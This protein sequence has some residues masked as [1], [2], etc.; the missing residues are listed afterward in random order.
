MTAQ[1]VAK[2]VGA[3]IKKHSPEILTAVGVVGLAATAYLASRAGWLA[4]LT[5]AAETNRRYDEATPFVDEDG[6]EEVVVELLTPK[7][8]VQETW[9]FYIPVAL[10]GAVTAVSMIGSN[11]ISHSRGVA[12]FSAA[13]IAEQ[14]TREIREKTIVETS[15]AK[16]TKIQDEIHQDTVN[17]KKDEIRNLVIHKDGDVK[18]LETFT[19]NVFVSNV[20]KVHKAVNDANRVGLSEGCV[21]LNTFLDFLGLPES[22]AGEVVGWTAFR[23]IDISI[24]GANVDGEP[25]LTIKYGSNPPSVT[26]QTSSF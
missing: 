3:S 11:R 16:E 20:E 9:K 14:A 22:P 10:V 4:G 8:I 23:P 6:E 1:E 19:N 13:A 26:Y 21:S 5:V 18:I 7:E 12:L 15:K 25:V 24:G 2:S 17:E